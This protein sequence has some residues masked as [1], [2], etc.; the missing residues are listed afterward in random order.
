MNIPHS[1]HCNRSVLGVRGGISYAA[2]S[3]DTLVPPTVRM[4]I[5]TGSKS[6]VLR[7][8][9]AAQSAAAYII[10]LLCDLKTSSNRVLQQCLPVWFSH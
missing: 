2:Y 8:C 6:E 1:K 5:G 10:S 7:P 3:S 4:R 9:C